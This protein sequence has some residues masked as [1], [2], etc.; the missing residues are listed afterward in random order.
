MKP[1]TV[2]HSTLFLLVVIVALAFAARPVVHAATNRYLDPAGAD[3]GDCSNPATPCRTLVYALGQALAGDTLMLAAGTYTGPGNQHVIINKAITLDGA[4]P[5]LTILDYDAGTPNPPLVAKNGLLEVRASN[6]TIKDL[7]VRDVPSEGG[8]TLWGIRLYLSGGTIDNTLIDNVHFLNNTSRGLEIHNFTTVTDLTV[9]NSLFDGNTEHG[10]RISSDARVTNLDVKDSTFQ[11]HGGAGIRHIGVTSYVQGLDVDNVTFINNAL[12][13]LQLIE[14]YNSI[15]HNSDFSGGQY[16]VWL[17]DTTTNI[18]DP[19]GLI[20][21]DTNTFTNQTLSAILMEYRDNPLDNP[22]TISGNTITQDVSLLTATAA[23]ID[24]RLHATQTHAAVNVTDN[25]VTLSGALGAA[26]AAHALQMRGGA[27]AVNVNE[28]TFDGGNVGNNGGTPPTSGIVIHTN[29]ATYGAMKAAAMV[30]V[31][32]NTIQDFVNG[33][34]LFDAVAPGF[35]GV[36]TT[37]AIN[38]NHNALIGNSDFGARSGDAN[39]AD[40]S[41]NWWG[42]ASGPSGVG[43]G[44]GDAV[45]IQLS[46]SPWLPTANLDDTC[47]SISVYDVFVAP[48][49]NGDIVHNGVTVAH[50]DEDILAYDYGTDKWVFLFDGSDV[51]VTKNLTGFTFD[52]MGCILMSFNG[53]IKVPGVGRVK[54]QDVVR[55]CPTTLGDNTSGT[56]TWFLDGSDVGLSTSGEIIDALDLLPDGRLVLSTKG[57]HKV[58]QTGGGNVEGG[59]ND[60]LVFN[61]TSYGENTAG[62]FQLMLSGSDIPGMKKEN[63]IGVWVNPFDGNFY[64]STYDDHNLGGVVGDNNDIF[65]VEDLG[66]GSYNVM[67]YWDGDLYGLHKRAHSITVDL[68]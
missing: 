31:T 53:A 40:A 25:A 62:T 28:N 32:K 67:P 68:P 37:A 15:V 30:N 8:T 20:M 24:I 4:G 14:V 65:I 61:Y 49:Q 3:S 22:N 48:N 29:D 66:G 51:G 47:I 39:P 23:S 21:L 46:F 56:F 12:A 16:G 60:V 6:V 26:T 64:L 63:I 44:S 42:D 5:A 38:V 7:T 2:A 13:G 50:N 33:L 19:N 1:R 41:C 18:A 35:G 10:I 36:P 17:A 27:D 45:S 9:Q 52:P 58:P 43:P 54:M 55:F 11:N 57:T 59:K 34:S